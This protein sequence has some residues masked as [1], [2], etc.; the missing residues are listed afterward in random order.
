M[1]EPCAYKNMDAVA[2]HGSKY[3]MMLGCDMLKSCISLL[4]PLC[5]DCPE[6]TVAVRFLAEADMMALYPFSD[7]DLGPGAMLVGKLHLGRTTSRQGNG[8]KV[9]VCQ[10]RTFEPS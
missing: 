3:R 7:F 2:A 1:E 9:R 4:R 6:L 10:T 8:C 5:D